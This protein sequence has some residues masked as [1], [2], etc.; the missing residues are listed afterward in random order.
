MI[1][2]TFFNV[3]LPLTPIVL[4]L[5]ALVRLR[6]AGSGRFSNVTLGKLL[7]D[8]ILYFLTV[9]LSLSLAAKAISAGMP[10]AHAEEVPALP[11]ALPPG[12]AFGAAIVAVVIFAAAL[13]CY[14]FALEDRHD[15]DA[16]DGGFH[17]VVSLILAAIA[18]GAVIWFRSRYA[19][20]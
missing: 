17:A 13:L 2:W 16:G 11:P 3:L 14:Y 10:V 19:L 8:G 15:P 6:A 1:L 18:A 4:T 9:V 12:L 5:V 7:G 20:W